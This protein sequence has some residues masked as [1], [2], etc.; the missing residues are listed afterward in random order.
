[1]EYASLEA[2]IARDGYAALAGALAKPADV[3]E[4]IK[5]SGLRGRGG[6]GFPTGVKW[7]AGMNAA[8]GR[9]YMVCNADEGDPGAFMDRS[10]LEGDPH[11]HRG[12]AAGRLRHRRQPRLR[13]RARGYPLAVERLSNAI[14]Q[15]REA[16][17]LG[18]GILGSVSISI[19]K[20]ASA[21]AR[22]SAARKPR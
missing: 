15:A 14:H 5:R 17:L 12:H 19:W 2:Y 7:E 13:L 4:E 18:E 6:A 3:V 16:G 21:R 1:M 22:S 20:S 8:E 9:K 11:P 10:I